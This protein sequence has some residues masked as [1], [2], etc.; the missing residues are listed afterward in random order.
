MNIPGLWPLLSRRTDV[1]DRICSTPGCGKPHRAKGLCST[2]YNRQLPAAERHKKIVVPCG[3]C[4]R[5]CVKA[6]DRVRGYAERFCSFDCRDTWRRSDRL[7]VLFTG[8]VVRAVRVSSDVEAK[9]S[10]WVAGWCRTCGQPFVD[11]QLQA[12]SCSPRCTRKYW[13][14]RYKDDVPPDVWRYVME[15]DGWRCQICRRGI[16]ALLRVPNH[17]AGTVDHI[18]PRCEGGAHDPA[19]LRASHFICNT[20][21]NNKG[22]NEQLMLIG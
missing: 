12:R 2:C 13:T 21:R 5:P 7:P 15:R 22:G 18:V 6:P 17:Q 16:P 9:P 3:W 11:S 20:R 10:V 14:K 19:N 1:A 4:G 8:E